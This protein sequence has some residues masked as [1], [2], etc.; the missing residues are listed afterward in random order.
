MSKIKKSFL[1]EIIGNDSYDS[2]RRLAILYVPVYVVVTGVVY[3]LTKF[4]FSGIL[5]SIFSLLTLE[6][7]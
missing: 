3:L 1:R 6:G 7:Y 5:S 2:L 4:F